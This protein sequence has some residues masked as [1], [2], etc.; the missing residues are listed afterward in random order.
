MRAALPT[1]SKQFAPKTSGGTPERMPKSLG[2]TRRISDTKGK[3]AAQ[4]PVSTESGQPPFYKC[5]TTAKMRM[6]DEIDAIFLGFLGSSRTSVESWV[7]SKAPLTNPSQPPHD[8]SRGEA[9]QW[10]TALP[11]PRRP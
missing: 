6:A 10:H 8:R 3:L 9:I 2:R 11:L 5:P 4:A 7:K 1:G